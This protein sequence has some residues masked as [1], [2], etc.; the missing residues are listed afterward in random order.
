MHFINQVGGPGV[1]LNKTSP[2][3]SKTKLIGLLII[4]SFVDEAMKIRAQMI[5]IF[6]FCF[7]FFYI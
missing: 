1:E 3:Y 4:Y 2:H 7:V 6:M 5:A